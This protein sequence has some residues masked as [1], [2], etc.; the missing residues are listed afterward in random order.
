MT[1]LDDIRNE[2]W[3][4][5]EREGYSE[6]HDDRHDRGEIALAG[7]A[8]AIAAASADFASLTPALKTWPWHPSEFK[9]MGGRRDLVRACALIL[10]EIERIDRAAAKQS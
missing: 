7:A 9:P 4:Q 10:A 5:Q 6:D 8:Y 1:A 3:R 2:R